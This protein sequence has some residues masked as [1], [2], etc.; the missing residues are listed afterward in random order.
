MRTSHATTQQQESVLKKHTKH[1]MLHAFPIEP[2]RSGRAAC[3]HLK[4][5]CA[6]HAKRTGMV[7]HSSWAT[8]PPKTCTMKLH[9]STCTCSSLSVHRR[10]RRIEKGDSHGRDMTNWGCCAET[11]WRQTVSEQAED[12]RT[13]AV[14]RLGGT[15]AR[16]A[17][18]ASVS[19]AC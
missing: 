19:E 13:Q 6:L 2:R 1:G 11:I 15:R 12:A 14:Q 3:R 9:R 5:R 8:S 18:P 16:V 7:A 17:P 4:R 10:S